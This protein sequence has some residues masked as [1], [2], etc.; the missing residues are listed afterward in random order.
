M[1]P[2]GHGAPY[3][4]SWRW[5]RLPDGAAA[6]YRVFVHDSIPVAHG[7]VTNLETDTVRVSSSLALKVQWQDALL[8]VGNA[9]YI[10]APAEREQFID[11]SAADT[12]ATLA[13]SYALASGGF[14]L[15]VPGLPMP[16]RWLVWNMEDSVLAGDSC[17]RGRW[18]GG[19]ICLRDC[20]ACSSIPFWWRPRACITTNMLHHSTKFC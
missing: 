17:N 7:R 13:A 16:A 5:P 4:C 6:E 14:I 10:F 3:D 15:S 12:T 9:E 20:C 19:E 8:P 1:N 2:L 18:F 11:E